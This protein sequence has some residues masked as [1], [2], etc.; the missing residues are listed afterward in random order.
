M[1][2]LVPDDQLSL[3]IGKGG[4]NVRLAAKLLGWKVD[5]KGESEYRRMIA[6]QAFGSDSTASVEPES[7]EAEVPGSDLAN[8]EMVGE[9]MA[10]LLSENGFPSIASIAAAS[11][12][13]LCEVPGIGPKRAKMLVEAASSHVEAPG[14]EASGEESPEEGAA[15]AEPEDEEA[16]GAPSEVA[17]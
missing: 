11:Q 16:T 5:L 9:K 14:E 2:V 12:E 1:E 17:G 3:A 7:E 15:A 4:Q 13:E 8:L 10:Q 6:E